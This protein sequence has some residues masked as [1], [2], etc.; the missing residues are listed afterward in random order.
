[1]GISPGALLWA[2]LTV[3]GR[4]TTAAFT[5]IVAH[6]NISHAPTMC[7]RHYSWENC[8]RRGTSPGSSVQPRQPV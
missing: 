1:M 2:W 7:R 5:G 4:I 8:R 6:S 3:A